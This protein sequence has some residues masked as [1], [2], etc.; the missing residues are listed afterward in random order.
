MPLK[1][2]QTIEMKK[3]PNRWFHTSTNTLAVTGDS[4]KCTICLSKPSLTNRGLMASSTDKHR[5][6]A[7]VC[8]DASGDEPKFNVAN[9]FSN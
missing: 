7:M 5:M 2:K 8:S 9:K 4:I 1:N 3:I 6:T